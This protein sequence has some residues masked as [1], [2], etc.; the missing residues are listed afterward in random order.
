MSWSVITCAERET[1]YGAGDLTVASSLTDLFG[2]F[3]DPM[4]F[5]EWAGPLGRPVLRD[6]R[7]PGPNGGRPDARPCE[8]YV[9]VASGW[10]CTECGEP[11][12]GGSCSNPNCPLKGG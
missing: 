1:L 2:E 4:V 3:G 9:P 6:Y 12:P 7:W 8:H 11:A 5:T 10:T